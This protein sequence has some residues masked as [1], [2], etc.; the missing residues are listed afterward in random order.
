MQNLQEVQHSCQVLF[1]SRV[2]NA[3]AWMF[4]NF[5]AKLQAA[6]IVAF[7]VQSVAPH[8]KH[9]NKSL[10]LS[11]LASAG[12]LC[13]NGQLAPKCY[14][15]GNIKQHLVDMHLMMHCRSHSLTAGPWSSFINP[16]YNPVL[17]CKQNKVAK[18]QAQHRI[19]IRI[20]RA[21]RQA[22]QQILV[23]LGA[24]FGRDPMW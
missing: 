6:K 13:D 20:S 1:G 19:L 24:G 23:S 17:L 22:W 12:T 10:C 7:W 2:H 8:G 5:H 9:G 14:T 16:F 3:L 18:L 15:S 11:V 4:I 21:A